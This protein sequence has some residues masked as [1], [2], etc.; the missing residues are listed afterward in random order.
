MIALIAAAVLSAQDESLKEVLAQVYNRYKSAKECQVTIQHIDSTT[1]YPGAYEQKLNWVDD[2]RFVLSVTRKGE[3]AVDVPRW[4]CDG[5]D[6]IATFRNGT[7][8]K[9]SRRQKREITPPW[10]MTAGIL[11][12]MLERTERAEMFFRK[13]ATIKVPKHLR[14]HYRGKEEVTVDSLEF[15]R[16]ERA[17]L[18]EQDCFEIEILITHEEVSYQIGSL[19]LSADRKKLIGEK[20]IHHDRTG[21]RVYLDEVLTKK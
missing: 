20:I 13:T 19:I 8:I 14:M 1:V 17:T 16:G 15:G 18:L 2:H 11:F 6:V 10:E 7:T 12:S 21:Y 9:D 5:R 4:S 3:R